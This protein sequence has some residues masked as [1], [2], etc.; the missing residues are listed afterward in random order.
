MN[1]ERI[2][3]SFIALVLACAPALGCTHGARLDTPAGF[4]SLGDD[5]DF[6]YRAA[7][8]RGVVL[9]TRTEP[10][11]VK[12]NTDFWAEALDVRLKDRGYVAEGTRAVRTAKGL[13]GTQLRYTTTKNGRPH[14]YWVTVIATKSKVY[15]IEA[16]GDRE[17]FDPAQ[18]TVERAIASLDASDG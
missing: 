2:R 1:T 11:D 12:A 14:R 18:P 17:A 7:S 13:A 10:N 15:V 3:L 4:A 8:A 5:G 6:S 16:A 9:T